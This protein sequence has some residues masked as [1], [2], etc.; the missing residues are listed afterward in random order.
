LTPLNLSIERFN[1][2]DQRVI[3]ALPDSVGAE[4][5]ERFRERNDGRLTQGV[6]RIRPTGDEDVPRLQL[7]G[8]IHEPPGEVDGASPSGRLDAA[9]AGSAV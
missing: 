4:L 7:A 3:G 5:I 8:H 1:A 9:E 6:A 2:D